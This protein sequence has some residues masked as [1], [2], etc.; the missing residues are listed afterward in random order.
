MPRATKHAGAREPHCPP[1]PH[2]M[3][4]DA[5]NDIKPDPHVA[6]RPRTA[7]NVIDI[8]NPLQ[9]LP[10]AQVAADARSFAEAHD[11]ADHAD[12]FVKG[13]LVA[14]SPD[15]LDS[16][17]ELSDSD[18]AALTFEKEH[19]WKCT[20]QLYFA[21]LVCALGAATEGWDIVGSNGANLSFPVE[22]G[23]A[24]PRPEPGASR[25]EWIVGLINSAPYMAAAMV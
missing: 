5:Y 22:F 3:S 4:S 10:A 1:P 19:K 15:D 9:R 13:A 2:T 25:D 20:W 21:A 18:R 11:L 23:I 24:R 7:D 12:D 6:V 16:I 8:E 14:R 17:P